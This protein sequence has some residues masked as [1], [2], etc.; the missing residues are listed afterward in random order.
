MA[1]VVRGRAASGS[2]A[3]LFA[4]LA[5][6]A[7]GA[8]GGFN[9][10]LYDPTTDMLDAR[11][12]DSFLVE[13]ET[14]EGQF[15]MKMRRHWA[16][17]GV[18]RVYHLMSNDFYAGARVY[19]MVPGFVAQ[20]GFSGDPVLDSVWRRRVL[21]DEPVVASNQRGV[22]SFAR[23]GPRTRSFTLFVNLD[24]NARLDSVDVGG[25][26]GYP[27]IG[28]IETNVDV[29]DV[30][31]SAYDMPGSVQDSIRIEGNDFARRV[32]PQLD[33]IIGTRVLTEWR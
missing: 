33:S 18:D 10:A 22:V 27:P 2:A 6:G 11:A 25:I 15:V 19:R 23:A 29:V 4:A 30:F 13:V 14:S 9:A 26:I 7:V 5:V 17:L 8:C 32:Y 16:P 28:Q 31:Y 12:P 21:D 24:D 20:W 1:S 3:A